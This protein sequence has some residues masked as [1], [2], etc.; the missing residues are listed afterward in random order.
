MITP[1][2]YGLYIYESRFSEGDNWMLLTDNVYLNIYP[3]YDTLSQGVNKVKLVG[4]VEGYDVQ[5]GDSIEFSFYFVKDRTKPESKTI[6][7]F[8]NYQ[9]DDDLPN[10]NGIGKMNILGNG[11][12]YAEKVTMQINGGEPE[13]LHYAKNSALTLQVLDPLEKINNNISM[14][15]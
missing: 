15:K 4:D 3:E 14:T 9:V 8:L 10:I 5:N 12:L 13:Q 11:E 6:Q 1:L 7:A 2:A